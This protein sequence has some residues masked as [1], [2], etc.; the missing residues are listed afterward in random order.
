MSSLGSVAEC[1]NGALQKQNRCARNVNFLGQYRRFASSRAILQFAAPA[2]RPQ[3]AGRKTREIT[4]KNALLAQPRRAAM[5]VP[6]RGLC[7]ITPRLAKKREI[8][9]EKSPPPLE[10]LPKNRKNVFHSRHDEI[11][12]LTYAYSCVVGLMTNSATCARG[13]S[14]A[15]ITTAAATSAGCKMRAR[16][17][18]VTGVGRALRIGVSTSPG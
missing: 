11:R 17:S 12:S 10:K 6:G 7:K 2:T 16:C 13:G 1:V 8:F 14:E 18:G 5:A 9:R 15:I 3:N 4:G